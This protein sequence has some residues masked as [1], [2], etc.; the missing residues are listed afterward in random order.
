MTKIL[1]TISY[2]MWHIWITSL[3]EIIIAWDLLQLAYV[4][5]IARDTV[6]LKYLSISTQTLWIFSYVLYSTLWLSRLFMSQIALRDVRKSELL[7][8]RCRQ[9]SAISAPLRGKGVTIAHGSRGYWHVGTA[10][11]IFTRSNNLPLLIGVVNSELPPTR[12]PKRILLNFFLD[13]LLLL[14]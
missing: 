3:S 10:T 1:V 14:R 9:C 5:H 2:A 6:Q 12:S 13:V 7:A 4:P 8:D 11:L